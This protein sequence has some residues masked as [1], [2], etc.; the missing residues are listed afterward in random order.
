MVLAYVMPKRSPMTGT[1]ELPPVRA[2]APE[3]SEAP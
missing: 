2:C 1:I 3:L